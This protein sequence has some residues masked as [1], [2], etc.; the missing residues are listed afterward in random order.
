MHSVPAAN[1]SSLTMDSSKA[2]WPT[3]EPVVVN[4]SLIH[5]PF[6]F[7]CDSYAH[8][9]ALFSATCRPDDP[10]LVVIVPPTDRQANTTAIRVEAPAFIPDRVRR[11]VGLQVDIWDCAQRFGSAELVGCRE[12]AFLA[13][14]TSVSCICPSALS[15]HLPCTFT[16]YAERYGPH[17]KG[18]CQITNFI[19]DP[20]MSANVKL[21]P[22]GPPP[23]KKSTRKRQ[24][25]TS[26]PTADT[27]QFIDSLAPHGVPL[28]T[29]QDLV[30][31]TAVCVSEP[32]LCHAGDSLSLLSPLCL[33]LCPG[34]FTGFPAACIVRAVPSMCSACCCCAARLAHTSDIDHSILVCV[35]L[36]V[37]VFVLLLRARAARALLCFSVCGGPS[38]VI[39]ES[40]KRPCLLASHSTA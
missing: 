40:S 10:H 28:L 29:I 12:C 9:V 17:S 24:K 27:A 35:L 16:P 30:D 39:T 36:P 22:H 5:F 23:L 6:I 25:V 13:P 31:A 8:W 14:I 7:S 18:M 38:R 37:S 34:V 3:S 32:V 2:I 19:A 21:P 11:M 26:H 33:C 15:L 4:P 1:W 20:A